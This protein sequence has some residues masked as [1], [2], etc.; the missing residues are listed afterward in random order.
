V[1]LILTSLAGAAR[2]EWDGSWQDKMFG[3]S[4]ELTPRSDRILIQFQ[5]ATGSALREVIRSAH[6]LQEIQTYHEGTR[7]A[8]YETRGAGDWRTLVSLLEDDVGVRGAAPAVVDQDG[9]TK[10][11]IPTEVTVQFHKNLREETCRDLIA[12]AGCE[13]LRDHWTPGYYTVS[14]PEGLT[15]FEAVRMWQS[16]PQTLFSEPSYVIYDD[17]LHVPND[18]HYPDQWALNNTGDY[19]GGTPGADVEAEAAWD[20][21]KGDPD[22]IVCIVDT[23]MDLDHPDLQANLLD[24]NGEDWDFSSTG[25]VPHD[26]NGHGTMVSG[27]AVAVQDNEIGVS[28]VAPGCRVMP[29][30]IN[31]SPGQNQNR[32]DAINYATSR[33]PEFRGLVINGSW[34]MS[35]GDFTAVEAACQNAWDNDVVLCF[36]SGNG[37]VAQIA[38]PAAY[39]TTIAVGASSPCDERKSPTSCDGEFWWGS[40]YGDE[41]EVVAPGVLIYTTRLGGGSEEIFAGTSAASPLAAGIC[42]LIWSLNPTLTN[43]EVRQILID[44]AE[45][46]VGPPGEDTP[47]WDPYM[48]YGRVNARRALELAAPD[49]LHDDMEAEGDWTHEVVFPFLGYGD[50]WHLSDQRNH[51]PG[52]QFSWMCGD[53]VGGDYDPEI[54]AALISPVF[55]ATPGSVITFWH[56]MDLHAPDDETAGDG[57][58]IE[59]TT[60]GGATWLSRTPVNGYTHEWPGSVAPFTLGQR[61]WSGSF[62]WR[63]DVVWL[64]DLEGGVQ[65]RFRMGTRGELP[66]GEGWYVDDVEVTTESSGVV[67]FDAPGSGVQMLRSWPNPASGSAH[68]S[69]RL[70][71]SSPVTLTV[72]DVRGRLVRRYDVRHR[73]P[74]SHVLTFDGRDHRGWPLPAGV[75]LIRMVT[76]SATETG[77]L[78]LV[79]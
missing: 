66:T 2:G 7:V 10:Y 77:R 4:W 39:A 8:V 49:T 33:R 6:G 9:F 24:R 47:G 61:V 79:H 48:G 25:L 18:E 69:F 73:R 40:Q 13:I 67:E 76:G 14:L 55:R 15:I 46:Q 12:G 19:G 35:S 74:G 21:H 65:V 71:E 59:A 11:Y 64:G 37:N 68:L 36:S 63:R 31:A 70:S 41:L 44:S 32:A 28:G 78:V 50:A 29:L 20:I 54:S 75:Y 72:H 45:D 43:A 23:G 58:V 16:H 5:P 57:A 22:V 62:D 51:T 52:G 56:W 53:T 38:F 60:D 26:G 27:I 17:F 30:K 42:A 34:G 1:F 3:K